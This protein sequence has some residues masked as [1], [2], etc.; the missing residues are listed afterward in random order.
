[1]TP[2]CGA[3][4]SRLTASNISWDERKA[5]S[6]RLALDGPVQAE[7]LEL[8]QRLRVE[9]GIGILF[10]SHDLAVVHQVCDQVRVMRR[11]R[12]VEHAATAGLRAQPP[13]PLHPAAGR[14]R[15]RT[16]RGP[17]DRVTPR[18]AGS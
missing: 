6:A 1:M 7:I 17:L 14:R 3:R 5:S 4:T 8:V 9:L 11:G 16:R 12:I 18:P 2:W 13:H 15:P 10:V